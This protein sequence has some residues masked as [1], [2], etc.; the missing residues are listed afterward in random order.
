MHRWTLGSLGGL[1]V[2]G[3]LAVGLAVSPAA[4]VAAAQSPGT[5]T[6]TGSLNFP[7]AVVPTPPTQLAISASR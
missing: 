1:P 6:K 5:W 4:P 3:L 7:Q 2:A